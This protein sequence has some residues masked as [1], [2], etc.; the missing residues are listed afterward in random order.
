MNN[1]K[2]SI[3]I[4]RRS[5]TRG[6]NCFK[7][8]V[9]PLPAVI[10]GPAFNIKKYIHAGT[11][12]I[13]FSRSH[14]HNGRCTGP[15]SRQNWT[16]WNFLPR[17]KNDFGIQQLNTSISFLMKRLR[18]RHI[19]TE[20]K[21]RA[22]DH[23][24]EKPIDHDRRGRTLGRSEDEGKERKLLKITTNGLMRQNSLAAIPSG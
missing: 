20:M 4:K 9:T 7:S 21:K 16:T 15:Y 1:K 6:P 14:W 3:H 17:A 18:I 19:S 13:H 2:T 23:G 11:T 8:G 24:V 22:S 12:K 5:G 10:E